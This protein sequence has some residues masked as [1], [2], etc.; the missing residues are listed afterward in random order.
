MS[1]KF[2]VNDDDAPGSPWHRSS[3]NTTNTGSS[4][5]NNTVNN[6]NRASMPVVDDEAVFASTYSSGV[7]SGKKNNKS[8]WKERETSL[9][10]TTKAS[11]NTQSLKKRNSNLDD[12]F[13]A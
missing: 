12:P 11:A 7:S 13:G 1:P 4:T 9:G 10:A 3:T 2:S 6:K 8:S 5:K